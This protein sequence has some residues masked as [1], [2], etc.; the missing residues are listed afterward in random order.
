M[1]L[2]GIMEC[3]IIRFSGSNKYYDAEVSIDTKMLTVFHGSV[4]LMAQQEISRIESKFDVED[5]LDRLKY[6][7]K[8]NHVQLKFQRDR[9]VDDLR[10]ERFTNRFTVNDLFPDEDP[11]IALKRELLELQVEN[12]KETVKD[13]RCPKKSEMR[14][15]GKNYGDD[16]Y[17]KIRVELMKSGSDG[18]SNAI[19]V[20]SF[21]YSDRK[22]TDKDFPYKK[23]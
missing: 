3:A 23:K 21:H 19:F 12:Y 13:L 5:Y 9:M 22:F 10:D 11:V 8:D 1:L 6:A 2:L 7:L 16:V 18:V 14:V 17:I 15:F 4:I 20:M